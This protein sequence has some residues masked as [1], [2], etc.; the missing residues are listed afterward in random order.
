MTEVIRWTEALNARL[1]DFEI[2]SPL[3]RELHLLQQPYNTSHHT[4]SVLPHYLAKIRSSNFGKRKCN[5]Q[6][7]AS[8]MWSWL[9]S[10]VKVNGSYYHGVVLLGEFFIFQHDS[11]PT[12]RARDTVRLL[13]Q[14]T[15][16]FIPPDLWPPNSPDINPVNYKIRYQASSN[17]KSISQRCTTLM[18][19]TS[20]CSMFGMASSRP[21]LTMQ[22]TS[23]VG[24]FAHVCGQK[25]DTSSNYC[26]NIHPYDKRRF[27]LFCQMWHDF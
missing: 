8:Q 12:Q 25:A 11:A 20:V 27:S 10:G 4:F 26:D 15:P 6:S 13:E 2:L 7:S 18:N 22:L 23:G 3:E 24:V 21:C 14:V 5:M 17:S 16:A 19:W 9:I 1:N